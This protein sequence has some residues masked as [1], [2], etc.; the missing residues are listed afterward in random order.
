MVSKDQ[1]REIAKLSKLYLHEEELETGAKEIE[2]MIKF[3]NQMN[4]IEKIADIPEVSDDIA[5]AFRED[6]VE[7]SFSREEIL[8]NVQGGKDG[9]FYLPKSK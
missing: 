1:V 7:T 9:F 3:V 6:E 8:S 4:D 2:S 5:N